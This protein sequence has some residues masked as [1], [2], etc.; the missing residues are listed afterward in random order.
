MHVRSCASSPES[1]KCV[2]FLGVIFI[3]LD[4]FIAAVLSVKGSHNKCW[5]FSIATL[6]VARQ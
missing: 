6:T 1:C 3:M 2:L 4:D 5:G